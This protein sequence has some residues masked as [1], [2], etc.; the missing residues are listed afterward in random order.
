MSVRHCFSLIT[1]IT[2]FASVT[3]TLLCTLVATLLMVAIHR[4][5]TE[6]LTAEIV[7]DGGRVAMQVERDRVAYPLAQN[8]FRHIQ[9][10]DSQGRVVISTPRLR[11]KPRMAAFTPANK[12]TAKSVVC[13]GVFPSGECDIVIAQWAY[14]EG[15]NWIVYSA[16]PAISPWVDPLL[17]A[18]VGGT[19]VMLAA[20]ITYLGRR[21]ATASLKPV[22]AIRAEL[23]EINETSLSRRAPVP[24]GD[25]EIHDLAVSVNHT[26]SRLQAAVEQQRQFASDASHDLRS[27]IA[28]IRAEVEDALLAPQET[29]VTKLGRT[30]L[31]GLERL[32]AIVQDLLTIARLDAGSPGA[33]D[34]IDLAELV[35]AE[36]RMRHH[37]RNRCE[38][39]LELGAVVIGDRLRIG[40]L[41]TNLIDNAERHADSSIVINVRRAPSGGRDDGRRFPH[42]A[43]VLEVIDDGPGIDPDKR[44]LVFQRFIR[45]DTAR[46]KDAGG[47]GLGLPIARQIA[48]TS[49]GTLRIEDSPRGAR[50][51]LRLPL[52]ENTALPPPGDPGLSSGSASPGAHEA[53]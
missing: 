7:A 18:L 16:S 34:T 43:A 47:T 6:S 3:A 4:F 17:A 15:G 44:E 29:N 41:L 53:M 20:V 45:L 39:S 40:R 21:I 24:L 48:E 50:F 10:V 8:P 1:R 28:A 23:D 22:T 14:R 30:I 35:A 31:G 38:F 37:M 11:D 13:G 12:A 2:L 46:G 9:V 27:P 51:V 32:Q 36:C 33:H 49:G 19:A 26:L 25:D 52:H 5:G 42:G